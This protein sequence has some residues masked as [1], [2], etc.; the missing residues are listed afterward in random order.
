MKILTGFLFLMLPY[1]AQ[2]DIEFR[3]DAEGPNAAASEEACLDMAEKF[4][5]T[6]CCYNSRETLI[7]DSNNKPWRC[8][9]D[10]KKANC[11]KAT[12]GFSR[13]TDWVCNIPSDCTERSP[14][15]GFS[16]PPTY[17]CKKGDSAEPFYVYVKA[18]TGPNVIPSRSKIEGKVPKV[19]FCRD[20]DVE[21]PKPAGKKGNVEGGR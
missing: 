14:M 17:S 21:N 15:V 2:A 4:L 3:C 11:K 12:E 5:K 16:D 6:D 1:I 18:H 10:K 7:V 8:T 9:L 19:A 13:R 20:K